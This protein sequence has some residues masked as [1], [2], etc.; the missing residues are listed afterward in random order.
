MNIRNTAILAMTA[1][2]ALAGIGAPAASAQNQNRTVISNS[3]SQAAA[4]RTS[5][6]A[7]ARS[8]ERI[9]VDVE[10]TGTRMKRRVC[11]TQAEWEQQGG[12]PTD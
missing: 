9:C 10:L 8:N 2:L 6:R 1:S 7:T 12:L 11:Q 3:D 4:A 5:R